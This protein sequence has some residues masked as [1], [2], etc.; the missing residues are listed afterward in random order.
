LGAAGEELPGRSR[1]LVCGAVADE[2]VFGA[3]I[4]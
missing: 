2:R 4:N 1:M 3:L